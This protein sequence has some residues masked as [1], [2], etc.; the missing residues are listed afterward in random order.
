MPPSRSKVSV[1]SRPIMRP[2]PPRR[3]IVGR[4]M[5]LNRGPY[6]SYVNPARRVTNVGRPRRISTMQYR[7]PGTSYSVGGAYRQPRRPTLAQSL[8]SQPEDAFWSGVQHLFPSQA[9]SEWEQA[10]QEFADNY[11]YPSPE[12][13]MSQAA[14]SVDSMAQEAVDAYARNHPWLGGLAQQA[15]Q[16]AERQ[17][18]QHGY[19]PKRSSSLPPPKGKG[20]KK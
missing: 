8:A 20:K 1:S 6:R 17:A 15:L 10:A 4:P 19:L 5:T 7:R 2:A 12:E 11:Q 13:L 3:P 18:R 14:S 16:T 9:V